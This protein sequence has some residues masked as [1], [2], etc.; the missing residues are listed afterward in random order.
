MSD[1]VK[2]ISTVDGRCGIDNMDLHISRR[3]PGRG[4]SVLFTKE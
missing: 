1:K 2:V 3:W 4:S